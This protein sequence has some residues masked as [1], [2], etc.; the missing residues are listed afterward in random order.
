MLSQVVIQGNSAVSWNSTRRSRSGPVIGAPSSEILPALGC[1]KP[2]SRRMSVLLPQ[3]E[4]PTMTVSFAR[5]MVNEQRSEEH[6]SELQSRLHLVC[7]LLLEK[8]KKCMSG[9]ASEAD[10]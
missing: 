10:Q 6:T 9:A 8:K 3:P 7:R 1:S 5:S 2:A 4:G